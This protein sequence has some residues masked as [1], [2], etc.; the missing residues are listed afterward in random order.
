MKK[1]ALIFALFSLLRVSASGQA[2]DSVAYKSL[3]PYD[4]HLTWLKVDKGLLVDVREPMEFRKNRIKDAVNVPS[5]WNLGIAADTLDKQY[6]IFV[7][8]TTG[9][10]S[11]RAAQLLTEKGFGSVVNLD[12]GISA[13]KK[14]VFPLDKKRRRVHKE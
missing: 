1:L 2:S 9:Y 11:K 10:R 6:T 7:Y 5:S 8:C 13:W 3:E 12:G 14:D 4:F